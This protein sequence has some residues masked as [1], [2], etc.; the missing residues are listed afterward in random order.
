M[1]RATT[2]SIT[3]ARAFPHFSVLTYPTPF[4]TS[5][6]SSSLLSTRYRQTLYFSTS[7]FA[8]TRSRI[9]VSS[10]KTRKFVFDNQHSMAPFTHSTERHFTPPKSRICILGAGNFGSC[11]AHHL[12]DSEHDVLL[13]S[14]SPSFAGYFNAYHKNPDFLT[15]HEFRKNV[16]AI[17]PDLPGEELLRSLDVLLFAIPTEG[18]R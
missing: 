10:S 12:S 14:R 4:F 17:G 8:R 15:D 3:R 5:Q 2:S 9:A 6:P 13:W 1:Q 11:L 16:T 7:T 18:L